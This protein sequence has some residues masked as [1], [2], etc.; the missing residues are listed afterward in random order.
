[1]LECKSVRVSESLIFKMFWVHKHLCVLLSG[2]L[3]IQW[4][5][6]LLF[7]VLLLSE[8]TCPY[9]ESLNIIFEIYIYLKMMIFYIKCPLGAFVLV[10]SVNNYVLFLSLCFLFLYCIFCFCFMLL[11]MLFAWFF[12][13]L[14]WLIGF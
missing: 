1:M 14:R 2:H 10:F 8:T 7:W 13:F 11:F 5:S 4:S 6:H 3:S 9:F 12:E